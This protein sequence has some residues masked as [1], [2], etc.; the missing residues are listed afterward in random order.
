[1]HS[2]FEDGEDPE[3][4]LELP[5]IIRHEI[6]KLNDIRHTGCII[7]ESLPT[8]L[9]IHSYYVL[10]DE[11][12]EQDFADALAKILA[13]VHLIDELGIS[14]FMKLPYK[15]TRT[16]EHLEHQPDHFYPRNPKEG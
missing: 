2:Y 13:N 10:L 12:K 15:N 1:M 3:E 9:K 14:G 6:E 7:F 11:E 4:L 8:H 16:F 5:Q